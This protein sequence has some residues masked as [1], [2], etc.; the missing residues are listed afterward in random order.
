MALWTPGQAVRPREVLGHFRREG[1][2]LGRPDAFLTFAGERV[3]SGVFVTLPA[4]PRDFCRRGDSLFVPAYWGRRDGPGMGHRMAL[5][6][7]VAA[8][9][10][11]R[12]VV[13][14][15]G[16]DWL[17][18]PRPRPVRDQQEFLR[19]VTYVAFRPA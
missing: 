15:D 13:Y 18:D 3:P 11:G 19:T 1:G 16:A 17:L 4:D 7:E 12:G 8:R 6:A 14:A 2:F 10:N 5:L 9:C